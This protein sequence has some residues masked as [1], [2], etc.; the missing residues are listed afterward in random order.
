MNALEAIL[1]SKAPAEAVASLA[2]TV[3]ARRRSDREYEFVHLNLC[4]GVLSMF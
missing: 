3:S 4:V 1:N 2:A